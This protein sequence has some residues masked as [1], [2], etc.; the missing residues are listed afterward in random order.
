MVSL[1][2]NLQSRSTSPFT[3]SESEYAE[4][5]SITDVNNIIEIIRDVNFFIVITSNIF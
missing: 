4:T 3:N 1:I 5:V 2:D